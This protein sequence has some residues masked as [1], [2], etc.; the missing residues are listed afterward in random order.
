MLDAHG[1][2]RLHEFLP[3]DRQRLAAD[4]AGHV[5]P[6]HRADGDEHQ[7]EIPPEEYHQQDDE[8]DEGQRIEHV[9]RT[10]HHGVDPPAEVARRGAPEHADQDRDRRRQH[11]DGQRDAAGHE[12]TGQQVAAVGVSAEEEE[13][14][15][16]DGDV[17]REPAFRRRTFRRPWRVRNRSERS[18]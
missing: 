1:L 5:E 13:V 3:L 4:D 10:H 9:D 12:R 11:T 7:H 2:G 18:K 15:H 16:F 14:L 8:E 17:D 6:F